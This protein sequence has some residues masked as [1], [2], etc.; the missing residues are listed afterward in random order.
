MV[1]IEDVW[2]KASA[3]T[4]LYPQ[5]CIERQLAEHRQSV[6]GIWTNDDGKSPCIRLNIMHPLQGQLTFPAVLGPL[7]YRP[8]AY[9]GGSLNPFVS[10]SSPTPPPSP[11]PNFSS[12]SPSPPAGRNYFGLYGYGGY[13]GGRYGGRS[14][15]ETEQDTFQAT[16][17]WLLAAAHLQCLMQT[18][19]QMLLSTQIKWAAQQ[20]PPVQI[21]RIHPIF[22]PHNSCQ[23]GLCV[24]SINSQAM[25]CTA[26]GNLRIPSWS[27]TCPYCK[28]RM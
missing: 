28:A 14:P 3:L 21:Q 10:T 6:W 4:I 25:T 24:L 27:K 2:P 16:A 8:K 23:P 26:K 22:N 17:N 13:G 5:R 18:T 12:P 1:A 9:T 20:S 7:N 15:G 11:L 19:S